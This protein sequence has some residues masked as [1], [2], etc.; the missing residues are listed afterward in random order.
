MKSPAQK[1]EALTLK[2]QDWC[3]GDCVVGAQQF[4]YAFD[5]K[6]RI[7]EASE[8]VDEEDP[9][10]YVGEDVEGLVILTQTCDIVRPVRARPFIE[11]APLIKKDSSDLSQIAKGMRPQFAVVPGVFDKGL[12]ADLDRTMTLEKP[13]LDSWAKVN[14]CRDDDEKR[15]FAN[16]LSRKRARAAFPNDFVDLIRPLQEK[17]KKKHGVDSPLGRTLEAMTEIRVQPYPN[18]AGEQPKQVKFLFLLPPKFDSAKRSEADKEIK[19][20]IDL[21]PASKKYQI[22]YAIGFHSE[23]SAAE[24]IA[25][26]LL[27]LDYLSE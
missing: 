1:E 23:V 9:A 20:L 26:D 14:G 3:Q 4:V 22:D 19:A 24:Y 25:S 27:D 5:P 8:K 7:T 11:V 10:P 12:V 2:L 15:R 13:I 18:W 6:F 17:C 16:A 21:I